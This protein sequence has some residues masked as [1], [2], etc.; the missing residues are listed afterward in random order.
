MG[1]GVVGLLRRFARVVLVAG[2]LLGLG[3]PVSAQLRFEGPV[4]F[5][6]P[7]WDQL[8][9]RA[10]RI[11]NPCAV[12]AGGRTNVLRLS[13]WI[14]PAPGADTATG[15]VVAEH[16]LQPL[17]CLRAHANVSSPL[18]PV[19]L[20]L[21]GVWYPS[22]LL[23]QFDG[24]RWVQVER[25]LFDQA[26][27][28]TDPFGG[29]DGAPGDGAGG[30]G[31]SDGSLAGTLALEGD[32]AYQASGDSVL[33]SAR[34]IAFNCPGQAA[35]VTGPLRLGLWA[36]PQPYSGLASG[37]DRQGGS[38]LAQHLMPT[39]SCGQAFENINSGLLVYN[40]PPAGTWYYALVLEEYL[41]DQW[42]PVDFR[43][44]PGAVVT[45][46]ASIGCSALQPEPNGVT[47]HEF[48]HRSFQHFFVTADA[49][50]IRS[51][52]SNPAG[53]WCYT[54]RKLAIQP[55]S[56]R[57]ARG[58]GPVVPVC[59][60]FSGPSFAP[61]SSHFYTS[62]AGECDAV[63]RNPDWRFESE[64]FLAV[65]PLSDGACPYGSVPLYRL[66]NNGR[67]GAPNHRYTTDRVLQAALISQGWTP[68]G[69]GPRR[70][71]MCVG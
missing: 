31:G 17:D 26:L 61:K 5:D 46:G 71:I 45:D 39:L 69:I 2:G 7:E 48:Y 24:E 64:S 15:H 56:R 49:A 62:N 19:R 66:Y 60:F 16:L 23:E 30:D 20:P 57:L 4:S 1:A 33:I 14:L 52:A 47:L 22:M 34:R 54:G 35:G 9:L 44:L 32:V 58:L 68:E 28:L 11:A 51:L 43:S 67:T 21:A 3:W 6:R 10:S 65:N 41:G 59:R 29:T 42:R 27:L 12:G 40:L 18:L 50:E 63:K 13:F 8:V 36:F 37:H 38:L 55:I 25:R 70:V 53:G